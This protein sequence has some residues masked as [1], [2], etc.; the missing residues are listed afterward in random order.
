MR[1]LSMLELTFWLETVWG[2][3]FGFIRCIIYAKYL[4]RCFYYAVRYQ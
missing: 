3:L 1:F 4:W 2:L